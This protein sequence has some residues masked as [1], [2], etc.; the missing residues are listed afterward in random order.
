[1]D[2][3]LAVDDAP[4]SMSES[5]LM[6]AHG[7]WERDARRPSAEATRS[8]PYC[9]HDHDR[10]LK[11]LTLTE[12]RERLYQTFRARMTV[13]FP[14]VAGLTDRQL[15]H[16]QRAR[17]LCRRAEGAPARVAFSPAALTEYVGAMRRRRTSLRRDPHARSVARAGARRQSPLRSPAKCRENSESVHAR[18]AA[19]ALPCLRHPRVEVVAV[20]GRRCRAAAPR[21]RRTVPACGDEDGAAR[22]VA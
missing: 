22:S 19:R 6:G 1:M 9:E 7:P 5:R 20:R 3:L 10:R 4:D 2:I 15:L 14:A 8:R 12:E 18:S 17:R 16:R 11:A 13:D 21:A